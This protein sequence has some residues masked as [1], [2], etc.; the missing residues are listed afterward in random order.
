MTLKTKKIITLGFLVCFLSIIVHGQYTKQLRGTVV[1]LVLQKPLAGATVSIPSI[2]RSAITDDN[3]VFRF[4]DL[5]VGTYQLS[6]TYTGFKDAILDNI[7]V[8]AGKETVVSIP[9][10]SLV[11]VETE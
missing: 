8:N 4:T 10:E 6:I 2:G 11:K 5:P 3:G 1:D 7:I 9:M